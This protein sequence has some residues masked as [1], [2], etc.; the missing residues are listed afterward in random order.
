VS[1]LSC[2]AGPEYSIEVSSGTGSYTY[3]V[4]DPSSINV[5]TGTIVAGTGVS[6]NFNLP[7][8]TPLGTYTV[9]VT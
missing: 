2:V 4:E 9:R 5:A 3:V 1:I 6:S 8:G 7:L